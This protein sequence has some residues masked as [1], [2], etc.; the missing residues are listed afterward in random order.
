MSGGE[1]IPHEDQQGW[2]EE[3]LRN[4]EG[5]IEEDDDKKNA[6][7]TDVDS[8]S[9]DEEV[10]RDQQR[11]Q[12]SETRAA[13]LADQDRQRQNLLNKLRTEE[14]T[15]NSEAAITSRVERM[16]EEDS[17]LQTLRA[18]IRVALG[19]HSTIERFIHEARSQEWARK[20]TNDDFEQI[21]L[22]A[23]RDRL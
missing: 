7:T 5:V 8:V 23:F 20:Y 22:L 2:G 13:S 15:A 19:D 6:Q 21:R 9:R 10:I 17:N 12:I 4:A 16:I 1:G 11:A 3:D 18:R 14:V